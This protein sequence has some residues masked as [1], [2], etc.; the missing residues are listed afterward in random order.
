[1]SKT[2]TPFF[3]LD[4]HGSV[5]G[6]ITA[7]RL[8]KETLVR[9]KPLPTYRYTLP[10]AY[11]RWLYED[12][13]YLWTQQT[14][15]VKTQHRIAGVR[16]HLTAFQM[17]MKY[18]LTNLPDILGWWKLDDNLGA[19][20]IDSSRNTNTGT[21]IGATP[22]PGPIG[23][24]LTFDGLN[25][26]VNCGTSP[27]LQP[28]TALSFECLFKTP[29]HTANQGLLSYSSPPEWGT[30]GFA[31]MLLWNTGQVYCRLDTKRS[32]TLAS[33]D[34]NLLHHFFVT[35]EKGGTIDI[36]IDGIEGPYAG[37]DIKLDNLVPSTHF[38]RL[39]QYFDTRTF[40]GLLDN[41]ILYNRKVTGLILPHSLRRYPA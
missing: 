24:T 35:W 18:N 10:Q 23:N 25:D 28:L 29:G 9:T 39:G 38:L 37:H 7:Q 22:A 40:K 11:Q 5:G 30:N 3:G 12:Y 15:A 33:Y 21:I 14:D 36:F 32:Y 20:T 26:L 6:S 19:T 1:M 2:K 31:F 16:H 4:A 41:A 17:W 27:S 34:D 8:P 13:A